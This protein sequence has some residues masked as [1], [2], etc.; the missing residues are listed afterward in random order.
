[1]GLFITCWV[2]FVSTR[3]MWCVLPTHVEIIFMSSLVWVGFVHHI[4]RYILCHR[5]HGRPL[6]TQVE[7]QLCVRRHGISL[8][9]T[10]WDAFYCLAGVDWVWS[11]HVEINFVSSLA[12]DGFDQHKLSYFMCPRWH[13]MCLVNTSWDTFC[14][15]AGIGG[16]WSTHVAMEILSVLAWECLVST[17]WDIFCVILEYEGLVQHILRCILCPR[18]N[19][20][21]LV[22]TCWGTLCVLAGMGVWIGQQMFRYF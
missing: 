22:I 1:M 11:T 7:I 12:C 8:V 3:G 6:S 14:V 21:G 4:L 16:V 18:L 17:C 19:G 2:H 13:G 15:L 10:S 9:N 5:W 20:M